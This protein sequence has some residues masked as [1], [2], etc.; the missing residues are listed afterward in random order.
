MP[1]CS[2]CGEECRAIEIDE[3]VG[4]TEAWGIPHNDVHLVI[5]SDCCEAEFDEEELQAI[6]RSIDADNEPDYDY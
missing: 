1:I 3:G 5:V 2:A 6:Q 4:Y